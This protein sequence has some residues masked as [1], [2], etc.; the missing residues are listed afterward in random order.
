MLDF[1][2]PAVRASSW[3][4]AR[5][6]RSTVAT[7][8][9]ERSDSSPAIADCVVPSRARERLLGEARGAAGVTYELSGS[10]R[11]NTITDDPQRNKAISPIRST[12]ASPCPTSNP[13]PATTPPRWSLG[14]WRNGCNRGCSIPLRKAPR[15][16]TT[17]SPSRRRMS[18]ACC[19]WATRST[20]PFRTAWRAI[21]GCAGSA[22]SGSSA[23]T[24]PASPPRPR[25]SGRSSPRARTGA[26]RPR[27]V[28]RAGVGWRA[29]YGG[30]IIEQLKRLGASADYDDRAI[31]ARRRLRPGRAQGLR[32]PV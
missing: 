10:H 15:R 8:G 16:R 13:R 5:R 29:Q 11:R 32:V 1:G 14:S 18:P 12:L 28:R 7:R 30:T 23:P 25:W 6:A 4:H 19:T 24:T 3:P 22:R 26:T 17:R 20:T 27:G 2:S 21:T 9:L 31:H